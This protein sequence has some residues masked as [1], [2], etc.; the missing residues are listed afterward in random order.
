MVTS[1]LCSS[2]WNADQ[3][4]SAI[5]FESQSLTENG[6]KH[7]RMVFVTLYFHLFADM[8][9]TSHPPGWVSWRSARRVLQTTC[10]SPSGFNS[11]WQEAVRHCGRRV[12]TRAGTPG[13][14]RRRRPHLRLLRLRACGTGG[15][16]R[17]LAGVS[18]RAG[19]DA[20][21]EKRRS[22]SP[23]HSFREAGACCASL[24]REGT[25]VRR[26]CATVPSAFPSVRGQRGS[27]RRFR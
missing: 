24:D 9:A 13:V 27:L 11:P 6:A 12:I 16:P 22:G 15:L 18:F 25:E 21:Q 3:F 14:L 23:P 1:A 20:T 17:R 7:V 4:F 8:I 2:L 19:S 5:T 26:S 10:P